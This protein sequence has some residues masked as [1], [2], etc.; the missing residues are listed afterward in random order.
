VTPVS[1]NAN[2]S[3]NSIHTLKRNAHQNKVENTNSSPTK[4]LDGRS[5]SGSRDKRSGSSAHKRLGE[6]VVQV[7]N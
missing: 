1:P 6:A 5:K 7:S 3:N 2:A 4:S